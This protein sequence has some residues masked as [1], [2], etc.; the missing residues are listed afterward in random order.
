MKTT[1]VDFD[2]AASAE[3]YPGKR[4]RR[5]RTIGYHR[6]DTTAEA[7][8]YVIEEMPPELM[9]GAIIETEEHRFEADQIAELYADDAYPLPRG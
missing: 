2:Y 5:L 9:A 3:L 4:S 6:F 7:L 1:V 8:R